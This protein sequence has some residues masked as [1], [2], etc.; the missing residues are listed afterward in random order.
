[1]LKQITHKPHMEN[2]VTS[3]F[4]QHNLTHILIYCRLKLIASLIKWN[5]QQPGQQHI[6][7]MET[8]TVQ[9]TNY[10][11]YRKPWR[12]V[13]CP[14]IAQPNYVNSYTNFVQHSRMIQHS[15]FLLNKHGKAPLKNPTDVL[16]NCENDN[17]DNNEI[18]TARAPASGAHECEPR[19]SA[20]PHEMAGR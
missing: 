16:L 10:S 6:C 17:N 15:S 4:Q 8:Q 7:A 3:E 9:S 11:P 2:Q 12:R 19:W 20:S 13:R 18:V 14:Y 1:M 5:T